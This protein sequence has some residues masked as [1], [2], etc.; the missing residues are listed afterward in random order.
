VPFLQAEF[1]L[2]DRAVSLHASAIAA[3]IF[4]KFRDQVSGIRHQKRQGAH[5]T[6]DP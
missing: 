4:Q 6:S 1:A 2:S 3:G 5:L